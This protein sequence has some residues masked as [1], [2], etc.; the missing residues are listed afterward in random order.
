MPTLDEELSYVFSTFLKISQ[1][2]ESITLLD[3]KTYIDL[4]DDPLESWE[5]DTIL[6]LD[7]ARQKA[8]QTK[9]QS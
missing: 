8:W 1:G 7:T 2:T 4:Y 3:I 6:G 9:S 5:I